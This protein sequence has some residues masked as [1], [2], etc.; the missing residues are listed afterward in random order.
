MRLAGTRAAVGTPIG[1]DG[2]LWGA[3]VAA[4]SRD[5]PLPP[6]TELRLGQFTELMAT[7]IA[8]TESHARADRLAE[9][10]ASLRRVATLVATESSLGEVFAMVAEEVARALGDVECALLRDEGDG[11]ASIV[12]IS[13]PSAAQIGVRLSLDDVSVTSLVLREGRLARLDDY[14]RAEGEVAGGA[15]DRGIRSSVGAPIVVGDRVWGVMA[16]AT[17]EARPL[18]A[19]AEAQLAQFS[20]LVATAIANTQARGEIERLADEQAAL[21]RVATLVAAGVQ[22]AELFSAVSQEVAQLLGTDVASVGRFDPDGPAYVVV[23]LASDSEEAAIGARLELDDALAL[24][25]VYRTG[26]A[27]R[28]DR[29]DWSG[30]SE[31]ASAPWRVASAPPPRSRA[32]SSSREHLW[33]CVTATGE[34]RCRSTPR[35]VSPTSPSSSAPRSPTRSRVHACAGSRDEQAALRRVAT[36]VAKGAPA[37]VVFGAVASEA[38]A[39]FGADFSGMLRIEDATTVSTVATWAADGDHPEVPERWTIE[40]GDPMM[41]LA[42]AGAAT[43]VEDWGSIPGEI[44]R[45][46][47][48]VLDV[49]CSV[50]CP[51]TVEGRPWGALAIHCKQGRPLPPDTESRITQF[52][53]L[54]GTAIANAEAHARADRLADEQAALRRVATLVAQEAPLEAVFAKVAD[55]VA[56]TL[57]DVDSA[58][59]ARRRRRN[60]D[61]GRSAGRGRRARGPRRD[62]ADARR[63]LH[64]RAGAARRPTAPDRRLLAA[65]RKRR[66]ARPRARAG[67]GG[68]LPDRR[69]RA[70]VGGDDGRERTTRSR[71]PRRPRRASP[72]SATSS[73]LPS[74]NAEA[75]GEV[76]RLADEQAAL[77]RVATLVAEGAPPTAVLDAVAAETERALGADGALLL[78]YEP[79]DELTV[80]ARRMPNQRGR[81]RER[82]SATRATT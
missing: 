38:G 3:I 34:R 42:E 17:R 70:H 8:N 12:A 67:F 4:T 72:G 63:G 31:P 28:V 29:R 45:V 78:R 75:R 9:A 19:D 23:G 49:S 41:L 39:L 77:R 44:A 7:A 37:S 82:A 62:A 69:G 61:R 24:T 47:R 53:D 54:V 27:A 14:A 57:G 64:D 65:G 71:S 10:Q 51:I 30:V 15:R 55:E 33:G 76:E 80:V 13:E 66:R 56:G 20:E 5:E 73:P 16:V 68:R 21:R 35:I 46:L 22:P 2:R 40:P 25:A 50:G 60:R 32:R 79:D 6:E 59:V 36:L 1:V 52:T 43:R 26:R 74:R 11:T 58:T 18:A 81:R 48:E